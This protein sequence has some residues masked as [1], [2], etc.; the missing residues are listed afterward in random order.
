MYRLYKTGNG[1]V[2]QIAVNDPVEDQGIE[3]KFPNPLEAKGENTNEAPFIEKERRQFDLIKANET[4]QARFQT[5]KLQNSNY[6]VINFSIVPT[7][8][9]ASQVYYNNAY[10]T[11]TAVG[12]ALDSGVLFGTSTADVTKAKY[13]NIVYANARYASA[14]L[15]LQSI[16]LN[17]PS[18]IEFY[19]MQKIPNGD[20]GG[21]IPRQIE[22]VANSVNTTGITVNGDEFGVQSFGIDVYNENAYYTQ[23]NDLKGM[24]CCGVALKQIQ[25]AFAETHA[26]NNI[27]LDLEIAIDLN[28]E[29]NN[30]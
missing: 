12:T 16:V 10:N 4:D 6:Q 24:R 13:Y 22:A 11:A 30:Y 23:T 1:Q 17:N 5:K 27:Q 3:E 29:G 20:F 7:D 2:K 25:L 15:P 14:I 19:L 28:T 8:S 18:Y 9:T 26:L 21:K